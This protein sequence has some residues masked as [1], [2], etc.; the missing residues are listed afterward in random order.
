[1]LLVVSP[2]A[3]LLTPLLERE[4]LDVH[5]ETTLTG[6]RTFLQNYTPELIVLDLTLPDAIGVE[7]P[8]RLAHDAM[9]SR[10]VIYSACDTCDEFLEDGCRRIQVAT[11]QTMVRKSLQV[12]PGT[13]TPRCTPQA[14]VNKI[15][16]MV[17]NPPESRPD[18]AEYINEI[19]S[20]MG[21]RG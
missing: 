7:G 10:V 16:Q 14:L 3:K 21:A 1:M 5:V 17:E 20:L 18:P 9:A 15:L 19:R 2:Q 8:I 11:P 12:V 13:T 6:A 4:G